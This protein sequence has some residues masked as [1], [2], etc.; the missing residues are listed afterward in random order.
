MLLVCCLIFTDLGSGFVHFYRQKNGTLAQ[1]ARISLCICCGHE[2][3]VCLFF[4]AFDND[5]KKQ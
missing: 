5:A 2:P 4:N 3:K 1:L